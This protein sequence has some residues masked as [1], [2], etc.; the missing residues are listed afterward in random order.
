MKL[1]GENHDLILGSIH[2]ALFVCDADLRLTYLN[3]AAE[4]LC[5]GS[6]EEVNG[7]HCRDTLGKTC[8]IECGICPIEKAITED[9][10]IL[11]HEVD[12][13]TDSGDQ[14]R[15]RLSISP[16]REGKQNVGAVVM[17]RDV[18]ELAVEAREQDELRLNEQRFRQL[19]EHMA[20]G[21][22]QVS[23]D[24]AI[25]STNRAFNKL[26]GYGEGEL[27]GKHLRD[28]TLPEVLEEN[29]KL[30]AQLTRGDIDHYRME[31]KFIHRK[32][33]TLYGLLD[34][35]LIR[36]E[37]G[38]P[39]H[40]LGTVVDINE[41][42]QAEEEL[43]ASE[44]KHRLLFDKANDAIFL[45]RQDMFIDCNNMTLTMFGC[46]ERDQI[47]GKPPYLFSP[48][49]QPDGRESKEKALEKINAALAGEPQ[50]FEWMHKKYDGELFDAEVSLNHF[51]L[52]GE[53]YI[54]AIV[55]DVTAR[56]RAEAIIEKS[57][58]R[59]RQITESLREWVWET[60]A[61][62]LYIYA[63]PVVEEILGYKP[64]EIVGKEHFYDLFHPDDRE[65]LKAGA[66]EVFAKGE[67]F[68]DFENRNI[69][70]KGEIVW[71]KT[72][73]VPVFDDDG[74]LS[75][76]IG[77]D[78]D[79]TSIKQEE[80][81]RR[82]LEEQ[83]RQA[84]KMEAVGQ[85]AG[86][87]AHDFNNLLQVINGYTEMA[88]NDIPEDASFR[89][90]LDAVARA[91]KQAATLVGQLLAFSRRQIVQLVDLDINTV[92]AEMIEMLRSVIGEQIQL[93]FLPCQESGVVHADRGMME[94]ILMNLCINAQDAMPTGGT[95][96]IETECNAVSEDFCQL[97]A[98]ALPGSYLVLSVTD[99]GCGMESETLE[100]IFE[101]FFTTKD[102]GKGSGLGLSMVYGIV[103][104]HNG[105]VTAYSEPNRGTT[106][107]VYLP[108][109]GAEAVISKELR[110]DASPGGTETILMA[111][112]NAMVRM[113][114]ESM[115]VQ[116]G[117]AVLVA[118]NGNQAVTMFE[119]NASNIDLLLLDV[120]MPELGGREAY[121]RIRETN[122]DLPVLFISG[123]S[124][125]AIHN[126][127]VLEEGMHLIKKPFERNE[128]LWKIR[129]LLDENQS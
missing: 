81:Q 29:L 95:L 36:N 10:S 71:L 98:W 106:I 45:M 115:L 75:S 19:Y 114:T 3:Q 18:S 125:N 118:E 32:G 55:R 107:K 42:K 26:L 25:E 88:L 28:I 49:V 108:L 39:L 121:D 113:M 67:T 7:Q 83:L 92:Y 72:S 34:A 51:E 60:D 91:G 102:I 59:F 30:Q 58:Q 61:D 126:A 103:K 117:Y 116:A 73:G 86:G 69:H 9:R 120:V 23:T 123:Y 82:H 47:V 38:K 43:K 53:Q 74:K 63:S 52:K 48:E 79:I 12:F 46:S 129:S 90:K 94:Q 40:F 62:G 80:E 37:A 105:M 20:I 111:E 127:F 68:R 93:Q 85:L 27:A 101:P 24:L 65:A 99:T 13:Q 87:I 17:L 104:Q 66:F 6:L 50:S 5:G 112:D 16:L 4:R 96:T 64:E 119:Q 22:L 15:L 2:E 128:L 109:S 70:K 97:H 44:L 41:R 78:M 31:R 56:K 84:H 33:H 14:Q 1:T 76:Y 77:T 57:E 21:A 11:A 110:T 100:R 8:R 124:E 54:Q 89:N 35:N 122:S